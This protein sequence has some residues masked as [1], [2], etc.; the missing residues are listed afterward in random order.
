VVR[1]ARV[2]EL[3]VR[4]AEALVPTWEAAEKHVGH[5]V[6]P[7]FWAFLWPGSHALARLL[8][9]Q[10]GLVAGKKVFD[11]ASGCGL[12]A[13]AAARSGASEVLACD[14]DNLAAE[15]QQLNA[16]LN[17]VSIESI[18]F[19]PTR[20]L[21][22][23]VDVVLAGD[24]CYER[25]GAQEILGWLRRCAREGLT[26]YLA[27]PGRSYAPTHHLQLVRAYDIPTTRELE[28]EELMHTHVWRLT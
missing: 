20:G 6:A 23:D 13:I 17:E 21:P 25:A 8:L 11:F 9:D 5:A 16:S 15:S 27:D 14:I 3:Q 2:P 18:L 28:T 10:P 7:P 12:A 19:N 22:P 26:V 1:P 4:V 24:V